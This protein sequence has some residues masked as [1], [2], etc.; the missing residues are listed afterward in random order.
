VPQGEEWRVKMAPQTE[1]VKPPVGAV[2][3]P[4]AFRPADQRSDR[5]LQKHHRVLLLQSPWLVM[6][7]FRLSLLYRMMRILWIIVLLQ[8]G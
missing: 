1:A 6:T 7:R 3:S 8:S 5:V 4:E 2:Q